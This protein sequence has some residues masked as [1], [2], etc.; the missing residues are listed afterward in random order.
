VDLTTIAATNATPI[1]IPS[2]NA[3]S[4]IVPWPV[5]LNLFYQELQKVEF[6]LAGLKKVHQL[7]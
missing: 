2:T 7:S 1:I 4:V 6:K 3:T 5:N